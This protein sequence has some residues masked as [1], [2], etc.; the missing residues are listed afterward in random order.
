VDMCRG[1]G[2]FLVTPV[3]GAGRLLTANGAAMSLQA[4]TRLPLICDL[5]RA[6]H[7]QVAYCKCLAAPVDSTSAMINAARPAPY[8][9]PCSPAFHSMH[10]S[11]VF[12]QIQVKVAR[13]RL[14]SVGFRS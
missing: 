12:I 1:T 7:L 8:N 2:E 3:V 9:S 4:T 11:R 10:L 13:T 6:R 5:L 14:P